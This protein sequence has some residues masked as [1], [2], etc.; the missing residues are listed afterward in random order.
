MSRK[1]VWLI[2]ISVMLLLPL[3]IIELYNPLGTVP[4]V[5]LFETMETVSCVRPLIYVGGL[6]CAIVLII[7]FRQKEGQ[8]SFVKEE[9]VFIA[10]LFFVLFLIVAV[11]D[12]QLFR[13]NRHLSEYDVSVNLS[14]PEAT[15]YVAWKIVTI[16]ICKG[17]VDPLFLVLPNKLRANHPSEV[18]TIIE[19]CCTSHPSGKYTS[20]ATGYHTSCSLTVIDKSTAT[21]VGR[22]GFYG[23]EPPFF[24]TGEGDWI[25]GKPIPD[26]LEYIEALPKKK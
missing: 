19:F 13:F 10:S 15:P 1:M 6:I 3:A 14:E 23:E 9:N 20:G 21:I 17:K 11:S 25:G 26:I 2:A 7:Y 8:R 22:T 18:G 24:K 16:D 5:V 12:L 4:Y